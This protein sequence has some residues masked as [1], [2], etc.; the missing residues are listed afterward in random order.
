MRE[1]ELVGLAFVALRHAQHPVVRQG[2]VDELRAPA[3]RAFEQ[4]TLTR[5][6]QHGTQRIRCVPGVPF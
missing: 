5:D 4:Q 1:A 2:D 6:G 3:T